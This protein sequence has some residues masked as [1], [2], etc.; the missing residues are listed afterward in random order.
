M[1]PYYSPPGPPGHP[2]FFRIVGA[3]VVVSG[4]LPPYSSGVPAFAVDCTLS[5]R[6][7]DWNAERYHHLSSPQQAWGRRVLE[8][9]PLEGSEH[10]LDLGCGSGRVTAELHCRLSHGRLVGTDRSEAMLETA[11]SWLRE[12]AAGVPLVRAD[13]AA[14]PFRRTFDAVFST[15]TFH[16]IPDHAALFRSIITALKPGGRLVA[17]CGGGANLALLRARAD[18]LRR[19]P[20]FAS[21]FD[22]WV[23]PWYFADVE[24]TRRRLEA[25]GFVDI[26]LSL[27]EAPTSLAGA[28]P[29]M[30]FVATVCVR[31]HLDR[32]PPR[33]RKMFLAELTMAA[34]ADS[35]AFTLD[36]WRLNIAARRPA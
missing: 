10:V 3:G 21:F 26:D 4:A 33:E 11:A 35:P 23:E 30:E 8:R 25:A 34:A 20:R 32:L 19:D 24:S 17:Q 12:Q 1:K 6:M 28:E 16:W 29:F 14:L 7:T 2:G 31:P 15:A 9:L 13:A 18:R 36:Y 22:D 27:E 5:V